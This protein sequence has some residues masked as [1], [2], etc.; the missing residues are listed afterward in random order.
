MPRTRVLTILSFAAIY[1]LWG[2][3]FLAIRVAVET[4]PPL[5]A[6]ATRFLLAG[7]LLYA[8]ARLQGGPKPSRLEWRNLAILST[9]LF[10]ISYGGVFWAE[11]RIPSGITSVLV[12]LIP[13]WTALLQICIFRKEAFRWSLGVSIALGVGGVAT[14]AFD[15]VAHLSLFGCLAILIGGISWSI[16]TVLSKILAQT[17]SMPVNSGA[18]M[19]LGGLMLL[20]CSG[21]AGEWHPAPSVSMRAGAAILYLAIA[22]SIVAFTAYVWL[23]NTMRAT[24]V[25]SYAYVNPVVAL[26]V[27]HWLGNE[28]LGVRTVVGA[29]LVLVSVVVALLRD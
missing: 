20:I 24:V 15:P 13:V 23:L 7:A 18:Q 14:L 29:G 28:V 10:L 6:A 27:G 21:L 11:K 1:L 16:G 12:A 5:F 3:T 2:S 22:G 25:T 19:L 4:V 9:F 26:L 8:G 17:K